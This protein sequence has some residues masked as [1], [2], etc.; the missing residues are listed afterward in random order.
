MSEHHGSY[1]PDADRPQ[2]GVTWDDQSCLVCG[3]AEAVWSYRLTAPGPQAAFALPGRCY[4]CEECRKL[5]ARGDEPGLAQRRPAHEDWP[6]PAEFVR[7]LRASVD[8][9]A[10]HK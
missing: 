1:R 8:G 9:A 2:P 3:R 10:V 6:E 4:L 7:V 5:L